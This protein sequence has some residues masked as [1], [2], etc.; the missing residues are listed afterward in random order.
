MDSCVWVGGGCQ[1]NVRHAYLL[2]LV[3][4]AGAHALITKL[5]GAHALITKLKH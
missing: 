5:A 4:R 2:Y 1:W 3:F